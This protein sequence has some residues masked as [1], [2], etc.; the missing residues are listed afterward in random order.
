MNAPGAATRLVLTS[1][2]LLTIQ[3]ILTI[4]HW[5]KSVTWQLNIPHSLN[6]KMLT[7]THGCW[8]ISGNNLFRKQFSWLLNQKWSRKWRLIIFL[9][10]PPRAANSGGTQEPKFPETI[11]THRKFLRIWDIHNVKK[12]K[13]AEIIKEILFTCRKYI[14]FTGF[15]SGCYNLQICF[16][17]KRVKTSFCFDM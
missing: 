12:Q 10:P 2:I 11:W 17:K 16:I 14:S 9:T 6:K 13:V 5:V 8:Y 15:F 7:H 3:T 1:F 4:F